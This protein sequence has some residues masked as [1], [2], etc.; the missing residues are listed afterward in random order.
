MNRVGIGR[1]GAR[2][3]DQLVL[4]R[5]YHGGLVMHQLHY[6]DEVKSF[7]E[8][9]PPIKASFRAEEEA[10]ADRLID[11]LSKDDFEPE[12]YHDD[13]QERLLEAIERK[14]SGEEIQLAPA[15]AEAPVVDLFDALRKSVEKAHEVET[16]AAVEPEAQ[17]V[18]TGPGLK[19][20]AS[21]RGAKERERKAG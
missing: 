7:Q 20:A 17:N 1:Y 2:G 9:V 10:L 12:K 18:E 14:V 16:P 3:K 11:Q 13:Y 21:R 19:K 15:P 6:A 5:P 8:V 4:L